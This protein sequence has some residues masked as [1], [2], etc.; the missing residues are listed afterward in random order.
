M[1]GSVKQ[2]AKQKYGH[3][4]LDAVKSHAVLIIALVA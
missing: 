3:L 2:S 1:D 4:I